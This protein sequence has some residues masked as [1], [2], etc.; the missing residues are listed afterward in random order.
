[1]SALADSPARAGI[2]RRLTARAWGVILAAW[3]AV[4][5]IA[6]HVLHHVGPLA[7]AAL[8][9]GAGGR[10]L[11]AAIALLVS[12]PF[13]LRIRRR[14]RSRLAPAV[15]L[16]AMSATFTLSTFVIAPLLTGDESGSSGPGVQ[17]PTVH[18][19]HHSK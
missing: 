11:F 15:A 3:G 17:Q 19:G 16:A 14:F 6:P 4:T 7:G 18:M 9:A 5:G 13:L 12:V 1:M 10:L 2:V 8:L